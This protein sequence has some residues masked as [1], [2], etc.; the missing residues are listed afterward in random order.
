[1][2]S[3]RRFPVRG[4]AIL[5]LLFTFLV[6]FNSLN[7]PFQFDDRLFLNDSNLQSPDGWKRM[8]HGGWTRWVSWLTFYWNYRLAGRNAFWYHLVNL[9]L[10]LANVGLVYGLARRAAEHQL[11]PQAAPAAALAAAVF[12]LHP[13][14][15]EAVNYIYQRTAL[16]AALFGFLALHFLFR[17][18]KGARWALA[19]SAV[20]L[21]LAILSK[22]SAVGF[23]AVLGMA[24]AF[25]RPNARFHPYALAAA[26]AAFLAAVT[27]ALQSH[28]Y[29]WTQALVFWRYLRLCIFPVGLNIDHYVRWADGLT[30]AV[31]LSLVCIA[32]LVVF[33]I[34]FRSR[35]PAVVFW[36]FAFLLLLLPTSTVV[37][38]AD[39]MFEHRLYLPMLGLACVSGCLFHWAY[40][41]QRAA[42]LALC[43]LALALAA[44]ATWQRNRDWSSEVSLW[45]SAARQS[46]NK[47]RP[48]Y[49]LGTVLLP[50]DPARAA[51]HLRRALQL[52]PGSL[53]A[54]H[55]FGQ[56][57]ARSE[58][59][60]AAI[61]AWRQGLRV[62][63]DSVKLHLAL[64]ALH[65]RR[66]EYQPAR[67][68]LLEAVRLDERSP[69][70]FYQLALLF[71]RFGMLAEAAR[72]AER[73]LELNDRNPETHELMSAILKQEGKSRGQGPVSPPKPDP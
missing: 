30:L 15:T 57:L 70:G 72:Y 60:A 18:L 63:P 1:M 17:F 26:T 40:N 31:V 54:W 20:S 32:G 38:V 46:P 44:G 25:T 41:R 34:W 48:H 7:G 8:H 29:F 35:Q 58:Q 66:R 68:H 14:Q 13:L 65:S 51:V 4:T 10:H 27:W 21:A 50:I 42:S 52:E 61:E 23:A 19:G 62:F 28:I 12:A 37:A 16:L 11:F 71:F 33:L 49:N 2:E 55:N 73:S 24:W 6:F 64:G 43:A 5:L 36:S 56:A 39:P 59:T 47:Y 69:A 53:D 67:Q 22:E 9:L 3:R 45:Q